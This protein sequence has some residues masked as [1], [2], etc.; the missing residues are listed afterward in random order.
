M[1]RLVRE[2]RLIPVVIIA[3]S[4]LFALKVIGL[5][6]DGYLFAGHTAASDGVEDVAVPRVVEASA[7]QSWAGDV[8]NFPGSP[9]ASRPKAV[10]ADAAADITGSVAA[11]PKEPPPA[12]PN[13]KKKPAEPERDPGG[14]VITADPAPVSP[15]ERAILERLQERRQEL[16]ARA[17]ELDMREALVKAAEKKLEGQLAEIKE[18][19]DKAKGAGQGREGEANRLKNLVTMYENMKA[20]DAAKIF[21]RL[22]MRV[23]MEVAT[24]INPR[25]MSDILAQMSPETAE[26]LT[27]EFAGSG[28][29]EK[30][31]ASSAEL[32]KIE[33]KPTN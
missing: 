20:K 1:I 8:F 28:S 25:R 27:V 15:A 31:L 3:I 4:S 19:D 13:A 29:A 2:L 23:L 14:K 16:D 22:D 9:A 18:S 33:G 10:V 30:S 21:D 26:R 17:R 6:V 32:P 11:K 12:D 7:K 24:Q 5:L